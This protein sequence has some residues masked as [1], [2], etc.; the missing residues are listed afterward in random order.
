MVAYSSYYGLFQFFSFKQILIQA[1]LTDHNNKIN[2]LPLLQVQF[3]LY[4]TMEELTVYLNEMS[5]VFPLTIAN[6]NIGMYV[7]LMVWRKSQPTRSKALK[8]VSFE[9]LHKACWAVNIFSK[10]VL[11]FLSLKKRVIRKSSTTGKAVYT[12]CH[13]SLNKQHLKGRIDN[14]WN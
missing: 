8:H 10:L 13:Y 1:C 2:A 4:W 9:T 14:E 5:I 12:L 11:I 7:G 6:K 3:N